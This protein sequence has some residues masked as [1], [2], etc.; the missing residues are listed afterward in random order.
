MR[1]GDWKYLRT[2]TTEALHN[3]TIGQHEQANHSRRELGRLAELRTRWR[4][5]LTS[6]SLPK[7]GGLLGSAVLAT[8]TRDR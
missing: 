2:P 5:I 7:A 6:S 3:L 1:R 4:G 8:G